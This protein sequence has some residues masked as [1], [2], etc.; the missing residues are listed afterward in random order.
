MPHVIQI[1][2]GLRARGVG[3]RSQT[4]SIDTTTAMGEFLFRVFGALA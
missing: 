1:V 2:G 3:L 4:E